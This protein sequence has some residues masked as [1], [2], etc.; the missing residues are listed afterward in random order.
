MLTPLPCTGSTMKSATSSE[1]SLS[2]SA[3]RS[4]QGTFSKPGNSGPKRDVNSEAE[5]ADSAPSVRPWKPCSAERT[6]GRRV[7][8]RPSLIAASTASVP[9]LTNR[10]RPSRGGPRRPRAALDRPPARPRPGVDEQDAAEPRRQPAQQLLGEQAG[11]RRDAELHRPGR[12]QLHRLDER[13]AHA[14]V[15]A[16]DVEHA[17][18]A[19][20]VEVARA[21]VVPE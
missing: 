21:R 5:V 20:D 6:R 11:E 17:E 15:V 18:A 3:E 1:R 4:F 16:A 8:A 10:T 9:E 2:S 14:P 12:L 19:E 13:R 7:A